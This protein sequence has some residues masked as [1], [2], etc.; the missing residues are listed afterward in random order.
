MRWLAPLLV[1]PLWLP[2]CLA[3]QPPAW[4]GVWEWTMDH[5]TEA[6]LRAMADACRDLHFNVVMTSPPQDKLAFMSAQCHERGVKLYLSTVFTGGEK[7]WQQ[8]MTPAEQARAARPP[9][10]SSQHGGEPLTADEVFEG[11][12][13]CW[14]RPE[15]REYFRNRVAEFARLPVD[16][17]AFDMVGYANYYRCYCPVCEARLADYRRQHPALSEEQA[18]AVCAEQAMVDFIDEMAA[19][20]RAARPDLELT[21]HVY[22]YFRPHP[23]YG[24]RLDLDTVGQTA[25]W[26]FHPHWP[27]EKVKRLTTE[28]VATQH[29]FYA[30]SSAAPFIGFYREPPEDARTAERVGEEL[31]IVRQSGARALQMAELGNL[32]R[33]PAVAKTV[34]EAFGH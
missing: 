3:A 24:N 7:A 4:R 28:L 26:F 30:D 32:V 6:G 8:V 1:A 27:L 25:A 23:Y 10:E 18:S 20:A 22:P 14:A 34:A 15:V 33:E 19:A 13:P 2:S 16:G 12:L 9:A 17:L 5:R 21:I 31:R 11:N 29:A